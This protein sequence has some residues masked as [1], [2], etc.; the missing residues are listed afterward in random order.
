MSTDETLPTRRPKPSSPDPA[1]QAPTEARPAFQ[2]TPPPA[3]QPSYQPARPSFQ[4]AAEPGYQRSAEPQTVQT[5]ALRPAPGQAGQPP[6]PGSAPGSATPPASPT[7][8]YGKPPYESAAPYESAGQS[9]SA[10]QYGMPP[11]DTPQY[12]SPQYGQES[13]YDNQP[14][15]PPAGQR[16]RPKRRKRRIVMSIFTVVVVLIVLVIAD[17]VAKQVAEYEIANQ[18]TSADSQIHPSV[19]IRGFPFLTQVATRDLKEIDISASNVAAGP[20][21][22][23]SVSAQAKGVHVNGSF[24]GGEVDSISGTVFIGFQSLSSALSSQSQGIGNVSLTDAGP[25]SIKASFGIGGAN[26]LTQTGTVAIK[27]MQISVTWSQS[28]GGGILGSVLGSG[29]LPPL[30]FTLP[31]LPAGLQVKNF[32]VTPTGVSVTVAAQHTTLSQ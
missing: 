9:G 31:K 1:G 27:G 22:I 15:S 16:R 7:P 18:I 14:P 17:V 21:T 4:P 12:G 24:N 26:L 32:V 30:S 20:V 25:H 29:T 3:P 28:G 10:G 19:T 5:E 23:T 2:P 11:T 6:R 8:Q 13:G